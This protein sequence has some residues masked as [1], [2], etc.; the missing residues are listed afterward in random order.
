[1]R[2]TVE[3][4]DV[5]AGLRLTIVR[6]GRSLLSSGLEVTTSA[7][8][9]RTFAG[10]RTVRIDERYST[11][12]GKRRA[13][14]HR[15]RQM[16]VDFGRGRQR[17][18]VQ[19]QVSADGV[20]YRYRLP[21]TRGLR[22]VRERSSF[23]V[24]GA[25][26]AWM[27]RW[28]SN[29]EGPYRPA[30]FRDVAPGHYAFPVLLDAGKGSFALLTEAGMDGGYAAS[31]LQVRAGRP[32]ELSVVQP[33]G[34]V[35]DT[36]TRV[37]PWRVAI[38]GD[39]AT[40][41]DSDLVE[42]LAGPAQIADTSWIQPGQ[43]AWSWWSDS[44]SPRSLER[45]KD[46][47]NFAAASGMEY[48]L[49]DEGWD[50]SWVPELAAYAA[51]RRVRIILWA[52]WSDLRD[53]ERRQQLLGL[54]HS[55]G[56]AG[57][58]LDFAQADTLPRMRWYEQV[59]RAAAA[60]HMVV[61]FHGSTLPRG[62]ERRWPNVLTYEAVRGAEHYKSRI[63]HAITPAD[64]A[65]LPF[66]RNAVGPMDYTPVAFSAPTRDTSSAAELALSVVFQSGL[67]HF[68]DSP[69]EYLKRPAAES[70][71]A[72]LPAAWDDSRLLGGY[73]GRRVVM[74]RRAGNDWWV[75]A[76]NAEE[77]GSARVRLDFLSPSH[78][79]EATIVTDAPGGELTSQQLAVSA[80]DTL[81]LPLGVGGGAAVHLRAL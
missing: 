31:S 28:V 18:Q 64:N 4:P 41:T 21:R 22:F 48:V 50:A 37:T 39:L 34:R 11:V 76:I 29:Y 54:W 80:A 57:V 68:A 1:V 69:E 24:P 42:D 56:V 47:V 59:A 81:T 25:D 15:A 3:Q 23:H 9:R 52:R 19:V 70:F 26:R 12:A 66:T 67:T 27:Q 60:H 53:A 17:I 65:T 8:E 13:H 35:A 2:A 5:R 79:Y 6:N 16:N 62:M 46:F 71:I 14:V 40:V 36:H 38:V 45:Q 75:G 49:V 61:N 43:A 73:P 55:W 74:A 33:H 20:A 51:Q 32:G 72:S 58:K 44:W 10:R 63:P 7:G 78:R 77:A 30:R